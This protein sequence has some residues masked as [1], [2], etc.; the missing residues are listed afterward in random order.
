MPPN[1]TARRVGTGGP[2][3]G[4]SLGKLS[5]RQD[6]ARDSARQAPLSSIPI[7]WG[8]TY[9]GAVVDCSH[10]YEAGAATGASL[11]L[12]NQSQHAVNALLERHCGGR[13]R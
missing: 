9:V 7:F 2:R 11:G 1:R 13:T 6:S 12:F 4:C 8:Q 5:S 10:G 3:H